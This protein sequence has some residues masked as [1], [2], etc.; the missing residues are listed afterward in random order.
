MDSVTKFY[1]TNL[2]WW[3]SRLC[4]TFLSWIS[5]L[6]TCESLKRNQCNLS[7]QLSWYNVSRMLWLACGSCCCSSEV[8][9]RHNGRRR[10]SKIFY[11]IWPNGSFH[12]LYIFPLSF[13]NFFYSVF[14]LFLFFSKVTRMIGVSLVAKQGS[15]VYSFLALQLFSFPS[16]H[17]QL[18]TIDLITCELIYIPIC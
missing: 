2:G 5:K 13:F 15:F 6:R 7:W 14:S 3:T 10:L 9:R 16:L 17:T 12:I 18:F 1:L 8:Y 4:R 11:I